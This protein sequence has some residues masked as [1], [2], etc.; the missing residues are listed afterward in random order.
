MICDV[1]LGP[2][3]SY[4]TS[5]E[6]AQPSLEE[7]EERKLQLPH[8]LKNFFRFLTLGLLHNLAI[9]RKILKLTVYST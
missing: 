3:E 4:N 8:F 7:C 5:F 6:R 9:V 1:A 2:T